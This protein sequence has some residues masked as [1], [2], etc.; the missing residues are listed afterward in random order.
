MANWFDDEVHEEYLNVYSNIVD[1]TRQHIMEEHG[2]DGLSDPN[3]VWETAQS[4]PSY[5]KNNGLE[6]ILKL[7]DTV[8]DEFAREVDWS[9]CTQ[10]I[11]QYSAPSGNSIMDYLP[12]NY[13][14]EAGEEIILHAVTYEI[15]GEARS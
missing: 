14:R 4:A 3:L 13:T 6:D 1:E 2:E 8:Y 15:T 10:R 11:K 9:S 7:S 5:M 12:T